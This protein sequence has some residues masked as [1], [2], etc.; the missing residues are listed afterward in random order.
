VRLPSGV[1][2]FDALVQGGFPSGAAVVVQ[3][4]AGREKDT[5]L[6]Q[7]IAEGLRRGAAALIVLASVSPAKY[8]QDLREAGV[9]VDRAVAENRLKFVDWFAYKEETVQDVEQDGPVFRASIDLANVGIAISRAIAAL[10][11]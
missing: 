8:Q 4:P 6:F 11:R 7:F 10:P 2:G 9:D 5:F 3:G 1:P